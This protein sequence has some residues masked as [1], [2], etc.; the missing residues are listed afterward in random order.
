MRVWEFTI[1]IKGRASGFRSGG[2]GAIKM[3]GGG[4]GVC[5]TSLAVRTKCAF[6]CAAK[7]KCIFSRRGGGRGGD[8]S[9][10]SK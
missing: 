9:G 1:S 6:V 7:G 8:L 5:L 2:G 3:T 10:F 4:V